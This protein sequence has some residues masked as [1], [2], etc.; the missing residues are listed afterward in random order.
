M[1]EELQALL[2]RIQNEGVAKAEAEAARIVA[3]A[4]AKAADIVAKARAEETA[5]KER[6]KDEAAQFRDRAE[7]NVRQAARDVVLGV[8]KS[9]RDTLDRL[10]LA[11]ISTALDSGTVR[12]LVAE[13]VPAFAKADAAVVLPPAQLADLRDALLA[14]LRD[15]AASGVDI[16]SDDGLTAGFRVSLAGGRIEYDFSADAIRAE[17]SRM[18]RPELAKLLQA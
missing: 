1:A 17:M 6:A 15:A 13:I 14:D 5:A 16:R 2:D 7:A 11:K 10:L 9:V 4:K 18:L 3:D 8:E 12:R